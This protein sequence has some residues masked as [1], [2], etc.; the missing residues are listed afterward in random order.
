MLIGVVGGKGPKILGKGSSC[1]SSMLSKKPCL[2]VKGT[3]MRGEVS[4]SGEGVM[5]PSDDDVE[6]VENSSS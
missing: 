5:T 1:P 3:M 2:L 4:W 6:I